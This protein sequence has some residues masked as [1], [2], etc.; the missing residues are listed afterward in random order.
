M[1]SLNEVGSKITQLSMNFK[2][3]IPEIGQETIITTTPPGWKDTKLKIGSVD[4]GS[5]TTITYRAYGKALA[6]TS[7]HQEPFRIEK[8]RFTQIIAATFGRQYGADR[9]IMVST[10]KF[11]AQEIQYSSLMGAVE[12]V[13]GSMPQQP[14]RMHLR[15]GSP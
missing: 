10:G 15:S 4:T 5:N 6:H 14:R 1:E 2:A 13:I 12:S 9:R 11:V 8:D 3:L 7:L